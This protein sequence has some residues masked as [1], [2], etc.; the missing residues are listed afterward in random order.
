[1]A[2]GL[3]DRGLGEVSDWDV[4]QTNKQTNKQIK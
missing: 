4:K 1:M 3:C 2:E